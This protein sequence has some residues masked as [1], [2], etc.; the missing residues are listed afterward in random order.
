MISVLH[1]IAIALLLVATPLAAQEQ[2]QDPR[3][4]QPERPT[5][6]THAHTVATGFLELEVGL[7]A[8]RFAP[9]RRSVVAPLV[10]KVGLASHLQMNVSTTGF[11]RAAAIGQE[12]GVGDIGVGL[13]WRLLDDAPLL[14]DFAL[15]PAIKLPT[16][17]SDRGT[18]TGTTDVGITLISSHDLGPVAMDLNVAYVRVGSAGSSPASSSALWTASFGASVA[19]RLGWVA[20][21]FGAPTIDGSGTPSSVELLTGPT[22][23]VS[24]ALNLDLGVIAPL[25]GDRPNAVYVG[26]VWNAGRLPG[27]AR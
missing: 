8:D 15:L 19:G 14:G 2:Q 6:A 27:F 21:L 3:L 16:G 9:G 11:A 22:Y 10:A 4:V 12:S 25:R 7:E 18:G 26:L 23:L 17:S 24:N 1:R 13:K 5:V 20:E